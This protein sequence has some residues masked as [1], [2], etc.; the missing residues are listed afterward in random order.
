MDF[1]EGLPTSFGKQVIMVVVDRLSKGAHF[2]PLSHLYSAVTVAQLFM[3]H[4]LRYHGMPKS[5]VSDRD[6]VFTSRFWQELFRLQGTQLMMSSS[7]HLQTDGRTEVV[8]RSLE[9]YLRCFSF[10]SNVV[11]GAQILPKSL[12]N[13]L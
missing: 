7:Y 5:I 4:I 11:R 1:V 12:T 9:A 8:S 10:L 2:V 6:P 3:D 13:F